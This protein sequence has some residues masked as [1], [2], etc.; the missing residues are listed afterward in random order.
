MA[1]WTSVANAQAYYLYIGTTVGA[2]NLVNSG[3][4]PL[5]TWPVCDV[6]TGQVLYARIQTKINNV[7]YSGTD[8]LFTASNSPPCKAT[9]TQPAGLTPQPTGGSPTVNLTSGFAWTTVPN[10][11]VYYLYVGTTVGATDLVNTG[12]ITQTSYLAIDLPLGQTLYVRLWTKAGPWRYLDYTLTASA[13]PQHAIFIAPTSGA[14]N[15]NLTQALQW[16]TGTGAQTYYLNVG[17]SVGASNYVNSG[18]TPQTTYWPCATIPAGQLVYASIQTKFGSVWK[19]SAITFTASTAAPPCGASLAFPVNG[20]TNADLTAGFSWLG[21]PHTTAYK[22]TVGTTPGA[23]DVVNTNELPPTQ[24]SLT[25]YDLPLGQLLYAHLSTRH[26]NAWYAA[27]STFTAATTTVGRA[28][29]TSMAAG[30]ADVYVDQPFNWTTVPNAQAY[31]L[32]VG[33]TQGASNLVDTGEIHTTFYSPT[34]LP[35]NTTLYAR[36]WTKVGDVWRYIDRTITVRSRPVTYSYDA[37]GRLRSVTDTFGASA[38]YTYDA[39][40]NILSI[41][42]HTA[43]EV[44]IFGFSPATGAPG[45]VVTISGAGFG[46][47]TSLNSVSFN[48]VTTVVSSATL[49]QLVVTVP[50]GATTGAITVGAPAGTATSST[51][52]SVTASSAAPT[53]LGF[54]PNIGLAG[55]S[56]A[57]NGTNFNPV[58]TNNKPTFNKMIATVEAASTT[59]ITSRVPSTATSGRITVKTPLGT[60]VS[61][62]DFFVPPSPYTVADVGMVDRVAPGETKTVSVTAPHTVALFVFDGVI[63]QKIS[64]LLSSTTVAPAVQIFDPTGARLN[65]VRIDR[66]VDAT[67]LPASG[68]YTILIQPGFSETANFA[69]TLYAFD[70]VTGTITPGGPAVGVSMPIPGQNGRFTFSGSAGQRIALRGSNGLSG[71]FISCDV[72]VSILQPDAHEIAAPTCMEQAGLIG[73]TVLS[74][75][76]TYTIVVDPYS[77]ATGNLTLTLYDVLSVA[78]GGIVPGGA[79]VIVPITTPGQVGRLTFAGTAGHRISLQGSG[80]TSQTSWC[81]V[82]AKILNPDATVLTGPTCMEP[83]GFIDATVLPAAGIYTILIVPESTFTGELTLLLHDVPADLSGSIA[84]GG[85]PVSLVL[86]TPGQNGRLTFSGTAGQRLSLQATGGSFGSD[87]CYCYVVVSIL[88]PDASVLGGSSSMTT[89]GFIDATLLPATGTYTIV[90]DPERS[91]TGRLT[92]TLFEVAADAVAT[93][94]PGGTPARLSMTT[95]GQNGRVTFAG[96]AGQRISASV[97]GVAPTSIG[98]EWSLTLLKPDDTPLAGASTCAGDPLF[99]DTPPLPSTGT[100]TLVVN[101]GGP[102][103]GTVDVTVYAVEDVAGTI[104]INGAP[105]VVSITTPGQ[106]AQLTFSGT[107][108]QQ[109][110]A[111]ISSSVDLCSGYWNVTIVNPDGTSLTGSYTCTSSLLSLNTRTLPA[112]GIY[113][114]VVDPWKMR[115]GSVNVLLKSP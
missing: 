2:N 63:N 55:S 18:E 101:P 17:S 84:P 78:D 19:T 13:A 29:F 35:T 9:M 77:S 87:P 112:T 1:A 91:G 61:A 44:S 26:E 6:P 76:G 88:K 4:T 80:W 81:D 85:A 111:S 83:S 49:T 54:A 5:T 74:T 104:V 105:V 20:A 25:V 52:F 48:G 45:S 75:A 3:E 106:N 115:M 7:W 34:P 57:I 27:D 90:I 68:T 37:L 94:T 110:S 93:T 100:Y 97:T 89:S 82:N 95:P 98:C 51:V 41:S 99:L 43:S 66:F 108:G 92:L 59:A 107:A 103:T 72:R 11:S 40:G 31:Y 22:L 60:A 28:T 62:A 30:A 70:D 38:R 16:T 96:T 42:R 56:V 33:T 47:A 114:V 102:T 69:M 65:L 14:T 53:I 24:T 15:V 73:P 109:V 21:V 46:T 32:D 79:P 64:L 58:A 113:K 39:V 86:A 36:L 23:A 50:A 8:I 12:E 67:V 71:Q 10:A